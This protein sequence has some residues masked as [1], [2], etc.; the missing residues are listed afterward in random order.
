ML[1]GYM[2]V[3]PDG[4]RQVPDLRRDAPLAAGVD[5]RHLFEDRANGSR[6]DRAGLAAA[7]AF[8]RPTEC[9]RVHSPNEEQGPPWRQRRRT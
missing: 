7:L 8:P 6:D 9:L 1:V 5:A 3:S 2:R 4:N